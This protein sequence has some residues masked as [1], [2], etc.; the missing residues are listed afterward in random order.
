MLFPTGYGERYVLIKSHQVQKMNRTIEK[1]TL[2]LIA[3]ASYLFIFLLGIFANFVVI[4]S[5]ASDPITTIQQ[6][7]VSVRL[8]ILA[9]M[10]I[11]IL[12]VVVAWALY[13]L[14][15]EDSL[16]LLSSLF[17]VIHATIMGVSIFSLPAVLVSSNEQEILKQVDTFNSIWLAGLFFF[18]VHLIILGKIFSKPKVIAFLLAIAGAMYMV[19]T[20]ANFTL[21]NYDNYKSFFLVLVAVPAVLAEMS[22][23]IWLLAKGGK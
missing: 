22:F 5:L 17:R 7:H 20:G 4:E 14:Y 21:P 13:E 18:G 1:R 10:I 23:A 15:K 2:S 11:V 16:S 12:D 3:G 8:G 6:N 19:D 9:F